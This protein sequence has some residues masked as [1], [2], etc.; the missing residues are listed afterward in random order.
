MFTYLI[1]NLHRPSLTS[2]HSAGVVDY[3]V[4]GFLFVSLPYYYCIGACNTD[5]SGIG[6]FG[7]SV[8]RKDKKCYAQP[9]IG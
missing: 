7:G 1:M 2:N 5:L 9:S 4:F 3:N 8:D 6:H